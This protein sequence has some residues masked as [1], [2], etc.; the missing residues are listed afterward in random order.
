MRAKEKQRRVGSNQN[1]PWLELKRAGKLEGTGVNRKG[2]VLSAL[3][4]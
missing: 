1:F 4:S 2:I 3:V